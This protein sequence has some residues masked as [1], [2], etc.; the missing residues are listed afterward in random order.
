MNVQQWITLTA[1]SIILAEGCCLS[2][3]PVQF[4]QLLEDVDPRWLQLA[5]LVETV[6]AA[7]LLAGLLLR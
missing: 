5:G 1:L 4:Q 2:L 6:I 7:A 3:F